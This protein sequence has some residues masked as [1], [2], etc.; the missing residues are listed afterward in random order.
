MILT[1]FSTVLG[2]PLHHV[3]AERGIPVLVCLWGYAMSGLLYNDKIKFAYH[4]FSVNAF[5]MCSETK[6]EKDD[7]IVYS[8]PVEATLKSFT[9]KTSD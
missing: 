6:N 5:F 4:V 7:L 1:I 9:I 2:N 8:F 3:W